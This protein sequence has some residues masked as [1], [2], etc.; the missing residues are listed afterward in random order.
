MKGETAAFKRSVFPL[1]AIL[2]LL[3]LAP[4]TSFAFY[5]WQGEESSLEM[6]GLLHGSGTML[7]NPNSPFYYNDRNIAALAG[8]ARGMLNAGYGNHLSLEAHAV[9][10]YVPGRLQTGGSRFASLLGPERSDLPDWSYD[11]GRSHLNLDRFNVQ[12]ASPRLNIKLGRQPVN[13]A[14]TFYF[15][16]NDFFSPF[17]AQTFYRTYKPGVDA[18]RADVQLQELSQLSLIAVLG[19]KSSAVNDTGW[20]NSPDA[21]RTSYL[22]RISSVIADFELALLG[23]Q[24]R[25]DRMIGGDLQ[26]ELF[27]WLGVRAEGHF[28][29]PDNPGQNDH[30]EFAFGLEHRWESSLSIRV[31]QFFHGSG[32]DRKAA[33]NLLAANRGFYQARHYTAA[34]ASYEFTP[35]LTGD[36]ASIYNW[37]DGSLLLALYSVY[38]LSDESEA[39]FS[40]NIPVGKRSAGAAINSEFGLYPLAFSVE[41]RSYF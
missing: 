1:Y 24:V 6:S 38:S 13:L 27:D 17:A 21:G 4:S 14:A 31:E 32:T 23:G 40:A 28:V 39:V 26:G 2:L 3:L 29:F 9:L 8:S 18:M 15:T 37:T 22:A 41:M 20:S 36:M 33:Y 7:R 19:Y 11:N 35:L 34:G 16:P 12:Y 30:G 10:S 25:R 5:Q